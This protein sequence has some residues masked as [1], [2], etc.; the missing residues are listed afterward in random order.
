MITRM[1]IFEGRVKPGQDAAMRAFVDAKLK[2]LWRQF[3]G[4]QEVRVYFATQQDPNGPVIPLILAITY[5]DKSAM[6]RALDSPGRYE[7]R[8]MLPA[9]YETYFDEVKLYH[10]E[11]ECDSHQP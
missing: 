7:S 8:D 4:A 3:T 10:Y 9:F 5:P 1:A 11:L 6:A 2:P